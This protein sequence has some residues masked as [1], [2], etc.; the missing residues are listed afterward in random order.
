LSGI[1]FGEPLGLWM[2]S[3]RRDLHLFSLNSFTEKEGDQHLRHVDAEN[4]KC[5]VEDRWQ[6]AWY[7]S[8]V[9]K[10]FWA[11]QV[12]EYGSSKTADMWRWLKMFVGT[13]TYFTFYIFWSLWGH[14]FRRRAVV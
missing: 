12:S 1:R 8:E 3:E 2:S 4:F 6:T 11:G 10:N 9:K 14:W 13:L 5:D 7:I